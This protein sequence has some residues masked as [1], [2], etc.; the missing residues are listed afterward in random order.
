MTCVFTSAPGGLRQAG[1][2][3]PQ[4]GKNHGPADSCWSG[5]GCG[6]VGGIGG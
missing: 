1:L 6:V 3:L 5:L 2:R 4:R